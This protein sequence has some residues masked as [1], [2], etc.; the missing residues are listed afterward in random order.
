MCLLMKCVITY[1][2]ISDA[3]V[4]VM[5]ETNRPLMLS[6]Y[7]ALEQFVNSGKGI[8]FIA[9]HYNADRNLN[10]WDATEVFNGYNRSTDQKYIMSTE[11]GDMRNKG[12]ANVGWLSE[13]FGLRFRFN[14][15]NCLDG[16][17]SIKSPT[18]S[19]GITEGVDPIL[20]AAGATLSIIDGNK[21]KGLVYFASTDNPTPWSYAADTGL[22]LV[23]KMKELMLL[24]Q[25][26]A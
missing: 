19:E 3:D 13:T 17:S 26:Q 12:L 6:E 8:Y 5:A 7:D 18:Y 21:A 22:Y 14:A 10:T 24:S 23:A 1:D 16:V 11:Y 4:F 25:N 2:A 9:D 15:I 20:M